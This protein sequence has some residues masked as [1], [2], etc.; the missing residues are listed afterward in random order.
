MS[1]DQIVVKMTVA[2]LKEFVVERD[3]YLDTKLNALMTRQQ[4]ELAA[5]IKELDL[6]DEFVKSAE[7]EMGL[8]RILGLCRTGR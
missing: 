5:A 2:E 3:Q 1:K 4:A 6:W 7:E 8:Q